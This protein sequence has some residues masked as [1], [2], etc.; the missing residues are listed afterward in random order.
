[1][2]WDTEI[3]LLPFY[4]LTWPEAARAL[5]MYR[6]N[7]LSQL[8]YCVELR[9]SPLVTAPLWPE[10]I[11]HTPTIR[12]VW[13]IRFAWIQ[14]TIRVIRINRIAWIQRTIRIIWIQLAIRIVQA[15]PVLRIL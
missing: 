7:T 12:V 13:I 6:S 15:G 4:I 10:P 8:Q 2:F 1:M 5:L 11:C 14:P 3:Y 9:G